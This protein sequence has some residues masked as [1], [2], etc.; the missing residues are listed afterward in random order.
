[1]M[2]NFLSNY[3]FSIIKCP[4]S[5]DN[6]HSSATGKLF[7]LPASSITLTLMRYSRVLSMSVFTDLFSCKFKTGI[8]YKTLK[9]VWRYV[10]KMQRHLLA[11]ATETIIVVPL[12]ENKKSRITEDNVTTFNSLRYLIFKKANRPVWRLDLHFHQYW[13]KDL[14]IPRCTKAKTLSRSNVARFEVNLQDVS[15][16]VD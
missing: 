1:M 5:A 7:L 9:Y 14:I 16:F 10:K 2:H 13:S 8:F 6:Q 11:S 3:S 15:M 12:Q 4:H